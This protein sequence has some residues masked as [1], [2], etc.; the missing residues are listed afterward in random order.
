V[1]PYIISSNTISTCEEWEKLTYPS[2]ISVI[3][4]ETN[5]YAR[6][7]NLPQWEVYLDLLNL[8]WSCQWEVV[9]N[10]IWLTGWTIPEPDVKTCPTWFFFN[11]EYCQI[12]CD[13]SNYSKEINWKCYSWTGSAST[14]YIFQTK[15]WLYNLYPLNCKDLIDKKD[16]F[17]IYDS[18]TYAWSSDSKYTDGM[19]WLDV[20]WTWATAPLKLYCDMNTDKGGWTRLA[21]ASYNTKVSDYNI[22]NLWIPHTQVYIKDMGSYSDYHTPINPYMNWQWFHMFYNCIKLS[23]WYRYLHPS[24][25]NTLT[26][27]PY[28]FK[29]LPDWS[30]KTWGEPSQCYFL[31][32]NYPK[33]C[34]KNWIINLPAWLKFVWYTDGES[35]PWWYQQWD[36]YFAIRMWFF[37]R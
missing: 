6:K 23:D 11:G 12:K 33:R 9:A 24:W 18:I 22:N 25:T 13:E 21:N 14:W 2:K 26:T 17:S 10:I 5:E 30:W 32:S 36:N 8:K 20:D 16:I 29:K 1:T 34:F 15:D 3:N 27:N 35:S 28:Q 7:T 37:V 31:Y 4:Y 19:Y